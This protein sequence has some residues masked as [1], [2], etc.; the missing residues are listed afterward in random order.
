MGITTVLR[1]DAF[2]QAIEPEAI[3]AHAV[4]RGSRMWLN[5]LKITEVTDEYISGYDPDDV[6]MRY[7][8]LTNMKT[9]VVIVPADMR[10]SLEPPVRGEGL[11]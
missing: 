7:K 6:R 10:T 3:V 5:R 9:V 2:G 8:Q 4:R 11:T 1:Q